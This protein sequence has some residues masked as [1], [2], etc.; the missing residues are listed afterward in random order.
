VVFIYTQNGDSDRDKERDRDRNRN[1]NR[2]SGRIGNR[3]RDLEGTDAK[4]GTAKE[5]MTRIRKETRKGRGIDGDIY[6]DRCRNI[7]SHRQEED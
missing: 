5:T 3:N 7:H 1:R 4:T 2:N 6:R